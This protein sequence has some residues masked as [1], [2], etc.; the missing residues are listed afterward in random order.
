MPTCV[1]MTIPLPPADQPSVKPSPNLT[2]LLFD[3]GPCGCAVDST[4]S[5][6]ELGTEQLYFSLR[7]QRLA[8]PGAA[9]SVAVER[10]RRQGR[11]APPRA[12]AFG[13]P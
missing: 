12:V 5:Y 13:N 2:L 1:G 3:D 6:T 10:R 4:R 7:D 11:Y 9:C 8:V